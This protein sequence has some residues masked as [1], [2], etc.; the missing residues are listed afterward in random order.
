[1]PTSSPTP[2]E[3]LTGV[4]V[5]RGEP[6]EILKGKNLGLLTNVTGRTRQAEA[7]IDLLHAS[8]DWHLAALFS[9]EHGIRGE[10]DAG[11]SVDSSTD[12]R[13]GL[14][15]YSLY[16]NT[17]RPTPAM[18]RGLDVLIY[19]IQDVGARVYTYTSTLLEAMRAAAVEKLG[20]VILDRPDP[21]GGTAVEGTVLDP[22]WRSFVG[23][24]PIAMRY[25]LTIGEL[26][27]YYNG[28][29]GVGA[30]LTVVQLRGWQRGMWFD[31]T[32]LAWVNPSPNLR[33][34]AAATL[35]P[36]CVLFEGTNV[37]EGRGTDTP[38]E[39]LGAP[40][41]DASVWVDRLRAV[42]PPGT[43]FEVQAR[44]PNASKFVGQVCQGV[45]LSI[46]DRD[47]LQSMALGVTL[48]ATLRDVAGARLTFDADTFD[49]LAGT[50]QVRVRLQGGQPAET[51]VDSWQAELQ[52]FA[53]I[54]ARYLL[55]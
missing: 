13:T 32:G 49:H 39:W 6:P 43:R 46:Q 23:A 14:P 34:L 3:V 12:P 33:S 40:W 16:G 18:L 30:D 35:Y 1:M 5:L 22:R 4:D 28:E 55:Y 27:R 7:T 53:Q 9:P 17:T 45:R 48:L 20:V 52:A 42:A 24:S 15:I 36:G 26:G 50:D 38:F 25:G 37:S 21:I 19:D 51:I 29:L 8:S 2:P 44:T 54:R 11:Q 47:A 31:Q 41:I 10:S